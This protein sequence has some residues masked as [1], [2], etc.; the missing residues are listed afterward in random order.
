MI[1]TEHAERFAQ[2]KCCSEWSAR[3][4]GRSKRLRLADVAERQEYISSAAAAAAAMRYGYTLTH[5]G[6][7]GED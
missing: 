2:S 5:S 6:K 7:E 1:N 4:A 3:T